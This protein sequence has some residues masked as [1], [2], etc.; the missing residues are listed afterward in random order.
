MT[1]T[2]DQL[3]EART[4]LDT[5]L[6][7][8]LPGDIRVSFEFFPPR[9][10]PLMEQLWDVV[11]TLAPLR[12]SFVSVT[13]GAGGSTRDRSPGSYTHIRAHETKAKHVCRLLLERK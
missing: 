6:F 1:T 5:P 7:A 4:A 3:R 10:D 2:F 13:Y 8:G 9:T 11:T 12:P